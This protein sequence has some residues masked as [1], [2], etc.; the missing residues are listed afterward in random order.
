M[1]ASVLLRIK[2][3]GYRKLVRIGDT[4]IKKGDFIKRTGS[5]V[6]VPAGKAMLGHVVD[7]LGVP[8]DGRG[9]L[10]DHER[11][12]VKVKALEII[13]RKSMHE[14]MQTRL[15]AVDRLVPISRGQREL[16]IG[17]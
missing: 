17:D 14:P 10:S 12:R 5:I 2:Q 8:I 11:R 6:D 9:A 15:K 13:K 7:A 1:Y 4:A 3:L 16:I